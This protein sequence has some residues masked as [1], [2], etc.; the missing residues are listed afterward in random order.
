MR[1]KPLCNS[2]FNGSYELLRTLLQLRLSISKA[3]KR[4]ISKEVN[5][6]VFLPSR[7]THQP[8]LATHVNFK[9]VTRNHQPFK[10]KHA[11]TKQ[12]R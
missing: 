10:Q 4:L 7:V 3:F 8:T 11:G 6:L 12:K 1:H 5:Y 2:Y 9:C